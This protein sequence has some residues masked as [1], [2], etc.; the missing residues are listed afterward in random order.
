MIALTKFGK[1]RFL[2]QLL[3]HPYLLAT[4][5]VG[6][7]AQGIGNRF[8]YFNIYNT[9]HIKDECGFLKVRFYF[10]VRG[11]EYSRSLSGQHHLFN[12]SLNPKTSYY[13]PSLR[14]QYRSL[15]RSCRTE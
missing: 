8:R 9:R 3:E 2:Q 1:S 14:Q 11:C 12:I 15:A 10:F 5:I 6:W 4:S 7:N 13:S